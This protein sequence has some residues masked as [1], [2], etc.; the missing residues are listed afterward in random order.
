[1]S[2][3]TEKLDALAQLEGAASSENTQ[4]DPVPAPVVESTPATEKPVNTL[5]GYQRIAREQLPQFGEL[6][7][8]SWEFAYR[9]P[10]A[11]EIA[12]FS[13]INEQD[14]PGIIVAVEDLIRKCIVIYNTETESVVDTG[15]ILDGHRTFFLLLLRDYYLPSNPVQYRAV[16]QTCHESY[17]TTLNYNKLDYSELREKLLAAYDGRK[18]KLNLNDTE[19]EFRVPTLETT[20]R[21]FKYIIRILRN[22]QNTDKNKE[23]DNVVYDKQFLF[24]APYLF[25]TGKETIRDITFKYKAIQRNNQ[26]LQAY[27]TVINNLKLDNEE[28]FEDTCP[29]CGAIEESAIRFPGGFKKLFI[30]T[31]DASGYF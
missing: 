1:M 6:Y 7:P 28:T 16:C 15:E 11:K 23:S 30:G 13:T 31:K 8:E 26:L 14:Q 22:N 25:V 17:D 2:K 10:T 29:H 20:G 12:N 9:C 3:E 19:I 5:D 24:I 27:L 4:V 21:I 18:F